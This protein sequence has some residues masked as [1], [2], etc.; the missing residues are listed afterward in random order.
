[1]VLGDGVIL[2]AVV[3]EAVGKPQEQGVMST[4]ASFP[5]VQNQGL[6]DQ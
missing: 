4:A 5:S 2:V 6:I 3:V 1:M